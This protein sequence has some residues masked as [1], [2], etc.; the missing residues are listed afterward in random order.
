MPGV[1]QLMRSF[2]ALAGR[3]RVP[4]PGPFDPSWGVNQRGQWGE[5]W[6]ARHYFRKR[7]AAVLATNWRGGGGE[8][9]LVCREGGDLVCVEVKM[10]GPD[11]PDPLAAVRE[12][13]RRRHLR[14]AG[15]AYLETLPRP[16][17][18]LRFDVALVRP[19]P[20]KPRAAEIELFVDV[21]RRED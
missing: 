11:D 10:R 2:R 14:A 1:Q 18:A 8:L 19:V 3:W 9:D 12:P 21:F 7:G 15:R 17:P 6:A 13:A 4:S 5:R 20:D 16:R